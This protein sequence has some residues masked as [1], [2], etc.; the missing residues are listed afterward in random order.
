MGQCPFYPYIYYRMGVFNIVSL[1][2]FL[3]YT[4]DWKTV[5]IYYPILYIATDHG[6]Q[7]VCHSVLHSTRGTFE[8]AELW[9]LNG[10]MRLIYP[11]MDAKELTQEW[12]VEFEA[13]RIAWPRFGFYSWTSAAV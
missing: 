2:K 13:F 11:S 7:R 5:E 4:L 10:Q 3:S 6:N 8:A 1:L 9:D 12:E